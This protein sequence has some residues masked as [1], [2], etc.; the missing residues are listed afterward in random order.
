MIATITLN[1][2]VDRRYNI[3]EI[4]KDTVQRTADY[5]ATAGG[6]GI[7]VSRVIKLLDHEL[8]ALGFIGGFSGDFIVNELNKLKINS[9]FIKIN[10]ETRT[11]LNIIDKNNN[12]IE[13]LENGPQITETEKNSFLV[14]YE[15]KIDEFNVITISGS[16]P[17]GV[18]ND[19]YKKIIQTAKKKNKIVILDTSGPALV[20]GLKAGPDI[21]KPNLSELESIFDFPIKTQKDYFLAAEKLQAMGA[22]NIALSVGAEGMYYFAKNK[23]YKV[24]VPE[25]KVE[26]VTGS[27]DS[28]VAGLAVAIH[29]QMS[30]EDML[31][32]ANAC[33]V[34]NAIEKKTAY[35]RKNKLN[36]YLNEISITRI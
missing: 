1:T 18:E 9:D 26:N 23:K 36:K 30:I 17:A 34:A 7:N 2:S 10:D 33:G 11:C 3:K 4:K 14:N 32:F 28:V 13:V 12:S 24:K 16:L 29:Q 35:L 19:F 21:I 6:K 25:I 20:N 8:L 15:K 5:Q 31:K 22:Q 27:G